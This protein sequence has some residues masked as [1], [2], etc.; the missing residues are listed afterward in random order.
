MEKSGLA[1]IQFS[2][3]P[4][5]VAVL[6]PEQNVKPRFPP[7]LGAAVSVGPAA[8]RALPGCFPLSVSDLGV[9]GPALGRGSLG[10]GPSGGTLEVPA[11]EVAEGSVY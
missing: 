2:G 6:P 3:L 11:N 9:V 10:G 5:S 1:E 7:S 4:A 8:L